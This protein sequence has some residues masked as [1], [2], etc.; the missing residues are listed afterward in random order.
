M[1]ET[2]AAS[3]QLYQYDI[4]LQLQENILD[5]ETRDPHTLANLPRVN[6]A[7]ILRIS[8][9]V[10]FRSAEFKEIITNKGVVTFP[11]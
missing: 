10:R 5:D 8:V 6:C 2:H 4:P 9:D 1:V 7:V 3:L 11:R